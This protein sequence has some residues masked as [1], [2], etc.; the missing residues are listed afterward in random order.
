MLGVL[1]ARVPNTMEKYISGLIEAKKQKINAAKETVKISKYDKSERKAAAA[2]AAAKKAAAATAKKVA[3]KP[4]STKKAAA[5]VIDDDSL[6]GDN[7]LDEVAPKKPTRAPPNIGKKPVK[8]ADA[9]DD[10]E[11]P[12]RG[13]PP[14]RSAKPAAAAGSGVVKVIKADDIKEEEVGAGMGKETAIEKVSEFY[15]AA[16][17]AKFEE[18]KWQDKVE[19]F[20][21][22]KQAIE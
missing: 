4:A 17:V 6:P 10:D 13:G 20:S 18:A 2:A 11:P 9:G 8:K 1:V 16:I 19:G 15:D 21:Q 14:A 7:V 12:K 5:M 22:L 3:S